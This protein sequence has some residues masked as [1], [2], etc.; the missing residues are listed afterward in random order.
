MRNHPQKNLGIRVRLEM[1]GKIDSYT[2]NLL[3]DHQKVAS[4]K[5]LSCTCRVSGDLSMLCEPASKVLEFPFKPLH[6]A[7]TGVAAMCW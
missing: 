3:P 4:Y 2:S 5:M 7:Y 6:F 1:V